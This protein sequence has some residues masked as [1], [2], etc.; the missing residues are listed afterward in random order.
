MKTLLLAI[1]L[2]C[3]GLP[4]QDPGKGEGLAPYDVV[5]FMNT[6]GDVLNDEQEAAFEAWYRAGGGFVGVHAATDTE[7]GW[8]WYGELVGARFG[9]HP[10]IQPARIVVVNDE[11]PS[12]AHLGDTWSRR[13]EWYE[14]KEGL[15][16]GCACLLRVDEDTYRGGTTGAWHPLAWQHEFDTLFRSAEPLVT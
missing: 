4:S 9:S 8:D 1:G 3:V 5:V 11:H 10:A 7:Y 13:D 12:T 16:E 15:H 2:V 14:F 6:T